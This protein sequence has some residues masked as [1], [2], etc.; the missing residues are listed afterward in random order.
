MK[1]R[2][3]LTGSLIAGVLASA[4]CIG[5]LLLGAAGIGSLGIAAALAPFR[6][7][8]LGL[9]AALLAAGFYLA[10]RQQP[11]TSCA[12]G[13]ACGPP[14]SRKNQRVVLWLV[15]LLTVAFATYPS[16]AARLGAARAARVSSAPSG[17]LVVLDVRGMTCAG[18]TQAV[19]KELREVMNVVGVRVDYPTARAEIRVA[20]SS[21]D[22]PSLVA[23]VR[24]AGYE[25][26]I[27]HD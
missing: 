6:P 12:S 5:P 25:A 18:C 1:E 17:A 19:E 13:E 9:T 21:T 23:A 27:A 22:L 4:C 16:W 15:T 10:Y 7:W 26:T 3:V 11:A 20:S 24:R 2:G 14:E 8:L